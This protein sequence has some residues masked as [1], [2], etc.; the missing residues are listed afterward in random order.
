VFSRKEKNGKGTT[1]EMGKKNDEVEC[2][3]LRKGEREREMKRQRQ[4][5]V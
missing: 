4:G 5:T 3:V 1:T 2:T